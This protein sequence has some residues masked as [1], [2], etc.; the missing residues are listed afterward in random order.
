MEIIKQNESFKLKETKGLYE[1]SGTASRDVSGSMNINFNVNKSGE[2]RFG[3]CHYSKYGESNNVN[4]SVNCS[5]EHRDELTTYADS[6]I[7]SVLAY[8]KNI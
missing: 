4:F 2:E 1:M 8:F 6:V 5:E 7:D 3:D